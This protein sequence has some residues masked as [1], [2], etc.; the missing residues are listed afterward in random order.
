[1]HR[2]SHIRLAVLRAARQGEWQ[3][4]VLHDNKGLKRNG[5]SRDPLRGATCRNLGRDFGHGL[6]NASQQALIQRGRNPSW[7][8]A[9][10]CDLPAARRPFCGEHG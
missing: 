8:T 10:I 9:A 5:E 7:V 6:G 3:D 1:M 4:L 2:V